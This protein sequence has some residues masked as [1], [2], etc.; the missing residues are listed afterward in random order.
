A[1]V[2]ATADDAV[3]RWS[4]LASHA[5]Q[6]VFDDAGFRDVLDHVARI[7]REHAQLHSLRI[8]LLALATAE[9]WAGRFNAAE[10]YHDEAAA[11][12]EAMGGDAGGYAFMHLELRAWQGRDE[13]RSLA[14]ALARRSATMGIGANV[15]SAELALTIL[16]MGRGEFE[17]ALPRARAMYAADP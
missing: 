4:V 13:T 3:T 2:N 6:I 5:A 12:T 17:R 1:I 8:A 11:I 10:A 9:T 14:D 15:Q 7:S 16:E